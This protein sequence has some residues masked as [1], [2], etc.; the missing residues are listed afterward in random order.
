MTHAKH[1][2]FAG[3]LLLGL[4]LMIAGTHTMAGTSG[5]IY[6]W[7]DQ[8]GETQY[9]QTPP[10]AGMQ[11][12]EIRNAPQPADDPAAERARLQQETEA[13]DERLKEHQERAARAE[14]SAKNE[15][16]RRKNCINAKKNLSELHEGGNKRYLMPDGEVMRL[17]EED[18]QK[19]IAE[20]EAQIAEFCK[21]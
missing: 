16:I 13:L 9:T 17:T 10:P 2:E 11:A 1:P 4:S 19:R 21:D 12:I 6:K 20:T 5:K 3:L 8:N 15:Q 7:V 14:V 18:R